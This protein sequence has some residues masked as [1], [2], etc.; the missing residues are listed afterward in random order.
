[1]SLTPLTR[2]PL[3][4][5]GRIFGSPMPFG[6]HDPEGKALFKFKEEKIS[7]IV[8]LAEEEECLRKAG[9]NLKALYIKE[10]FQVIHIAVISLSWPVP[11]SLSARRMR[12][13]K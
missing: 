13:Q 6:D 1:M 8:L 7:L 12:Y 9:R 5:P 11:V 10:G 3:P 2:L 4:L